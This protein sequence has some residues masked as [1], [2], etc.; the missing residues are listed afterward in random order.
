[1]PLNTYRDPDYKKKHYKNNL[2]AYRASTLLAK[3]GI[4]MEQYNKLFQDQKGCCAI[5]GV[6]QAEQNRRLHIDH[7]HETGVV[8]GLLCGNCNLALGHLK[9]SVE[10]IEKALVYMKG[11]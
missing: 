10:V 6:H 7:C 8:R 2:A 5:C 1:M 9:D 3:Y 4:T 11:F